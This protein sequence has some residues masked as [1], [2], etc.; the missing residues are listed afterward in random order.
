MPN[1]SA[2]ISQEDRAKIDRWLVDKWKVRNCP[3]CGTAKWLAAHHFLLDETPGPDASIVVPYVA[4][5]CA[6]CA[7]TVRFNAALMG[8]L[9]AWEPANIAEPKTNG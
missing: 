9:S 7:Y 3:I 6:N 2:E 8:L 4:L 5:F 1:P